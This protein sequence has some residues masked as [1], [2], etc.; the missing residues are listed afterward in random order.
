MSQYAERYAIQA[1][2]GDN[3]PT[4]LE[5]IKDEE[6]IGKL[7]DKVM[8]VTGVS[9]GVGVETLRAFHATGATVY[10]TVRNM[11]K[12]QKVIDEIFAADPSKK[13]KIE[14]L[15]IDLESFE[16]IRK[17]VK[18]FLEKETTLNILVN[19]AGVSASLLYRFGIHTDKHTRS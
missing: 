19:N 2:P 14:L 7:T 8:I 3:R 15:E 18:V 6:L 1:G 17:G 9:S 10:G 4:A 11:A 5:I 16:S 12:G 13:A